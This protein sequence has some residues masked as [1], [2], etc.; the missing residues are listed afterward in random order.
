MTV[1]IGYQI[2]SRYIFAST[3]R[4]SEELALIFMVWFA[5]IGMA[6]GVKRGIHLSIEYFF[7]KLNIKAQ[8]IVEVINNT[9]VFLFGLIL[10]VYGGKLAAMAGMSKMAATG[11]STTVLYIMVPIN[12]IMMSI[13]S[14][15]KII[16]IIKSNN[17]KEV[18]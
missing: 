4:W 15:I 2:V 17:S 5:F 16:D 18:K 6:I 1:I 3:P 11:L 10:F 7:N 13:Y 8:N 9:I 14:I 12:G